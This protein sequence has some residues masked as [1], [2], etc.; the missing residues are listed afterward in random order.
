[1]RKVLVNGVVL[2]SIVLMSLIVPSHDLLPI[3]QNEDILG[4]WVIS[5]DE[6]MERMPSKEKEEMQKNPKSAEI[7]QEIFQNIYFVFKEDKT[8][9]V[10]TKGY[11]GKGQEIEGE[12]KLEN[13]TLT[14]ITKDGIERDKNKVLELTKS[15][16]VFQ[17]INNPEGFIYVLV[18]EN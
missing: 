16:L 1:M 12:W 18:R 13:S 3:N 15:K 6:M 17:S 2:L 9:L 5:V 4:K 8:M 10:H 14:F 11:K 7:L